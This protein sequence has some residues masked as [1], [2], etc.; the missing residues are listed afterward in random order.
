[1]VNDFVG[2]RPN[3]IHYVE[4]QLEKSYPVIVEIRFIL[5]VKLPNIFYFHFSA[6]MVGINN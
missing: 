1:M 4:S 6:Y 3:A 5:V 2:K